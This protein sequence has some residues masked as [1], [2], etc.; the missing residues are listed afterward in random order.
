MIKS[1]AV[2]AVK[3]LGRFAVLL[4]AAVLA[5]RHCGVCVFPVLQAQVFG[6]LVVV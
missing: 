5:T 3:Y 2:L 4:S 6:C 1:Q